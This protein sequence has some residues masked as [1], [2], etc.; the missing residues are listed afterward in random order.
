MNANNNIHW[1]YMN[2]TPAF[3]FTERQCNEILMAFAK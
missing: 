2:G 3:L 1:N